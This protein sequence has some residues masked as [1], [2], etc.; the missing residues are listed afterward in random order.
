MARVPPFVVC[1]GLKPCHWQDCWW[2]DCPDWVSGSGREECYV[3]VVVEL[4]SGIQTSIGSLDLATPEAAS[5][6][7]L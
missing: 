3:R 1:Q 6:M 4:F 2:V 5:G 7:M